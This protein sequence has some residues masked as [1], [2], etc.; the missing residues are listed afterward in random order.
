MQAGLGGTGPGRGRKTR[1]PSAQR[2]WRSF[3]SYSKS[4]AVASGSEGARSDL[5]ST[6]FPLRTFAGLGACCPSRYKSKISVD[7]LENLII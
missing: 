6:F 2:R 5:L 4:E 7:S 3:Y 1:S